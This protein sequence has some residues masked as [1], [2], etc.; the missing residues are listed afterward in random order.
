MEI[1]I[2]VA[3]IVVGYFIE[4]IL[5][6]FLSQMKLII[7]RRNWQKAE[8]VWEKYKVISRGLEVVQSGWISN[9]FSEKEVTITVDSDFLLPTDIKMKILDGHKDEWE[10]LEIEN[11]SQIGI[12][13]IDP[14]RVS[15]NVGSKEQTHE[16]RIHGHT[17]RYFEFCSAVEKL[18]T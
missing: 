13:D 11:N 16:L 17:Y 10:K 18:D 9:K 6:F 12:S 4:I 8:I 15:D 14:H 3:G 1:I 2:F 7:K 5:D